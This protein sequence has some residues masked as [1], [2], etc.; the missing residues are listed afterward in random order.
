MTTGSIPKGNEIKLK[1]SIVFFVFRVIVGRSFVMKRSALEKYQNN[2]RSAIP[3]DYDSIYIQEDMD[4]AS[5]KDYVSHTYRIFD[6]EKVRLVYK[7]QAKITI[8]NSNES[9]TPMC[10]QCKANLGMGREENP[11][12][13]N[14]QL[15]SNAG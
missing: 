6:K 12:Y 2:P 14:N 7:V 10:E 11:A 1:E 4:E 9:Q 8:I 15:G 5:K 13:S 3:P